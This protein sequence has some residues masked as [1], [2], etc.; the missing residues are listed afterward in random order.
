MAQKSE[1]NILYLKLE[2]EEEKEEEKEKEKEIKKKKNYYLKVSDLIE[3]IVKNN[4][5]ISMKILVSNFIILFCSYFNNL[6]YAYDLE[7]LRRSLEGEY[8]KQNKD[9]NPLLKNFK[10]YTFENESGINIPKS[11]IPEEFKSI[12]RL[13][14]TDFIT[15]P[16]IDQVSI[17]EI[18]SL[19]FFL[20]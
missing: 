13:N 5:K 10:Y 17:S 14:E 15:L 20:K 2:S 18:A 3:F 19:L 12:K 6:N 9:I 8:R 7:N 1:N 4:K 16:K 11:S